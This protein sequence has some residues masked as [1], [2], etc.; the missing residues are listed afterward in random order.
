[1][2]ELDVNIFDPYEKIDYNIQ[3]IIEK[4]INKIKPAHI[5]SVINFLK[6]E[7]R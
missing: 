5:D 7:C 2:F 3:K 1:M 6:L 4:L